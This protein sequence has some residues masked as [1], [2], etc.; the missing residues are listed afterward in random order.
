MFE[1]LKIDETPKKTKTGQYATGEDVLL[2]LSTKHQIVERILEYREYKKLKSTYV[3]ALPHLMNKKDQRVHTNYGQA[4]TSTGRLSSNNPNLQNIPIRSEIGREIRRAFVPEK[5]NIFVSADYSQ[6]ELRMLAHLSG[7]EALIQAFREG[8]DIH[9][10]VACE[11]FDTSMEEVTDEQRSAAK[12][13]N[14]GIVYG[15]TP[16]GLARQLKC[17]VERATSIIEGYKLK[18]SGIDSFLEQCVKQASEHE[19]VETILHR[20]RFIRGI[21]ASNQQQRMLAERIAINSVVQGSAADLI[22]VA[23]K[24]VHESFSASWSS[25]RLLLQIHDELVVETPRKDADN[26]RDL[27]VEIMESAM[28]LDVP[29]VADASIASNWADCK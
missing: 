7:D 27:L 1:K 11:V 12:A 13:V 15:I 20:R 14:F 19:Y 6:V 28:S 24:R 18:F 26:I 25:T 21:H 29:L 9:R 17:E 23:M 22:K 5:G 2:K 3:D 10:T 8:Q 16:W 4:V